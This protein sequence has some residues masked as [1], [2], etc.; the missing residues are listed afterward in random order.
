MA[1]IQCPECG[2][3][4]SSNAKACI[5]CGSPLTA[6]DYSIKVQLGD[7][8]KTING[9]MIQTA[10]K[11]TYTF[12]NDKTGETLAVA[13][14]HQTVTLNV[15]KPTTIRC[16]VGRGF[17]DAILEY[18]PRE[19]AKYKIIVINTLFKARIE[20]QEVDHFN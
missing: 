13:N 20:F 14:Q 5:H 6:P 17:A 15:S 16:H 4:V 7:T 18:I 10:A 8:S 19:N 1:L 2:G 9:T 3:N 12:T 11:M